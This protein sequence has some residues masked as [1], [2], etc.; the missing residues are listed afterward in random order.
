MAQ[1]TQTIARKPLSD[2]QLE[3]KEQLALVLDEVGAHAV[4][5]LPTLDGC[6]FAMSPF[7]LFV[8]DGD[9][10]EHRKALGQCY[11]TYSH[12]KPDGEVALKLHQ[13]V[14]E[15]SFSETSQTRV[16]TTAGRK[17]GAA[18][19]VS[20]ANIDHPFRHWDFLW[21][22]SLLKEFA[23]ILQDW[24]M[25]RW[26]PVW[27]EDDSDRLALNGTS[28]RTR[29]FGGLAGKS[30]ITRLDTFLVSGETDQTLLEKLRFGDWR[31]GFTPSLRAA[32]EVL[33]N[34]G[35]LDVDFWEVPKFFN[36]SQMDALH[37][38][39][40]DLNRYEKPDDFW[41]EWAGGDDKAKTIEAM[42]EKLEELKRDPQNRPEL[43]AG[44]IHTER[45]AR[46]HNR[47][48]LNIQKHYLM[49]TGYKGLQEPF[50]GEAVEECFKFLLRLNNDVFGMP[51][52][53]LLDWRKRTDRCT[54]ENAKLMMGKLK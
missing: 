41:S 1:A 25:W 2:G 14:G 47:E 40:A 28:R 23:G 17:F 4:M 44:I 36:D 50:I 38:I 42:L 51:A 26:V 18:A 24:N 6:D 45:N 11:F 48:H 30:L 9:K 8:I 37:G 19:N 7:E 16:D 3:R 13:E 35:K 53:R 46:T 34:L 21:N 10:I 49:N 32:V 22:R 20:M 31:D 52:E 15:S 33:E 5:T 39:K 12:D 43:L 27:D 54:K 29:Y